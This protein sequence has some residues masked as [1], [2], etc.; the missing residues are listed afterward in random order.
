MVHLDLFKK[1]TEEQISR[2]Q[3]IQYFKESMYKNLNIRETLEFYYERYVYQLTDFI[4]LN[5]ET[6]IL[7]IGAGFGWLSIAFAMA[8]PVTILA[9]ELDRQRLKAGKNIAQILNVEDRISWVNGK[10]GTLPFSDKTINVE[11]CIEVIEHTYRD[12]LVLEDLRRISDNLLIITTPNLWFPIIAHDTSLPFCHWLPITLRKLY[13]KIFNRL[14]R[15]FDNLFWSPRKLEKALLN[16][17][18]TS[19]FAHY[20][21][22]KKYLDTFPFYNPYGSFKYE[23]K[24][25]LAK[26]IYYRLLPKTKKFGNYFT[27]NLASVFKRIK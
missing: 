14:D 26:K 23:F 27:P 9:I 7:D 20:S 5:D 10:L 18:R 24:L 3:Q 2:I 19:T 17:Q 11:Y 16:F 21:T 13:A 22:Y 25:S 15:E 4:V 6:F 1:I 8:T 12:P